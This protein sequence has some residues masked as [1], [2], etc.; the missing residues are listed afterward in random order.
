MRKIL[1]GGLLAAGS[2]S[3][4]AQSTVTMYGIAD[5]FVGFAKGAANDTRLMDGGNL[6]SQLGFR[7]VE[8]LGGGLKA[9]A[10]QGSCRLIHAAN[11]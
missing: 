6:A 8:D 1:V 10:R 3:A 9:G 2:L 11:C 5:T 7:G 4:F